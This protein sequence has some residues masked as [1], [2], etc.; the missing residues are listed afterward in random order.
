MQIETRVTHHYIPTAIVKMKN[1]DNTNDGENGE[2][3]DRSYI[4]C[5]NVAMVQTL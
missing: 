4:A 1:S 5:G 2:K 3:R